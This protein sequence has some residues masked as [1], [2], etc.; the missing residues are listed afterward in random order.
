MGEVYKVSDQELNNEIVA[1][2]I[3]L[4]NLAE[5]EQT[6][7]RF[8][9]EVLVARSLVHKNI[10]RI[11][12]LSKSA[13]GLYYMTMEYVE[14]QTLKDRIANDADVTRGAQTKIPFEDA[15]GILEQLLEGVAYA[16]G[17]GVVH[18]DLKPANVFLTT[19][20]EVKL[21]DFGTARLLE[22]SQ[23]LT[24]AGQLIGTPMYMS[25]EQVKGEKVDARADI[26]S[27]GI[28]GYEIVTGISPYSSET[29]M[30]AMFKHLNEPLPDIQKISPEIPAWY[31]D[32]IH[33]ACAKDPANRIRS[34][35]SFLQALR[36]RGM[37]AV[38]EL[39]AAETP[40][41]SKPWR[42]LLLL[43]AATIC[44]YIFLSQRARPEPE[45]PP[46]LATPIPTITVPPTEAPTPVTTSL[47]T[48][49]STPVPTAAPI[50]KETV[51]PFPTSAAAE[52]SGE[53]KVATDTAASVALPTPTE[54][55]AP[56]VNSSSEEISE[57][58]IRLPSMTGPAKSF[59]RSEAS[60]LRWVAE[61]DAV[62]PDTKD[63]VRSFRLQ[64]LGV[65]VQRHELA[66][67]ILGV[68]IMRPNSLRVGG[69]FAAL[70]KAE[71]PAGQYRVQLLK[72]DKVL[73]ETHFVL[74]P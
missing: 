24:V 38:S 34:A 17:K 52:T 65:G 46:S 73:A 23:T 16:H 27:L 1:L 57:I 30:T 44:A 9:N 7:Q 8:R 61:I 42:L 50:A 70:S 49:V 47:P 69:N 59:P 35:E 29:A 68:G 51:T 40:K 31:N 55:S 12:D 63:E 41:R 25:P 10:V 14:G 32:L 43:F 74:T 19:T 56:P 26:Y 15:L 60:S 64:I 62:S 48:L 11:F 18:R 71:L 13:D 72:A 4:P 21:L 39:P 45:K 22:N 33:N 53:M 54:T 6:F 58:M 2:K 66:V 67:S 20:G 36:A 3:L 28:I 37:P 5:D